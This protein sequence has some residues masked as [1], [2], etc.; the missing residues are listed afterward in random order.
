LF[1]SLC[2]SHIQFGSAMNWRPSTT[3]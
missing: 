3:L 1:H 2:L